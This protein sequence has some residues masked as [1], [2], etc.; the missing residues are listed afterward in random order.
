MTN[1]TG[2]AWCVHAEKGEKDHPCNE[3]DWLG[4]EWTHFEP[5]PLPPECVRCR[6]LATV[7]YD[8]RPLCAEC[9][10]KEFSA[11]LRDECAAL[12]ERC[13]MPEKGGVE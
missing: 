3:C 1:Q 2:C 4:G 11:S 13:R 6:C 8:G 7:E 12:A 10:A 9:W 5:R